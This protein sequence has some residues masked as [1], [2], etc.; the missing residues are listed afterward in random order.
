MK[1]CAYSGAENAEA[2]SE[3]TDPTLSA[4]NFSCP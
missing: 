3:L 4:S 2:M 1:S